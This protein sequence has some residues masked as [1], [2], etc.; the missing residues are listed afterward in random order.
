MG[1][2]LLEPR[3]GGTPGDVP[4]QPIDGGGYYPIYYPWGWG[5]IGVGAYYG[6]Y[7]PWG[8]G[9]PYR[10]SRRVTTTTGSSN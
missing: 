1:S 9:D 8:W 7:D 3:S 10:L 6:G 4:T 5:G 2:P